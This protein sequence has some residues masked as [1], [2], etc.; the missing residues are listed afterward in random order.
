[1]SLASKGLLQRPANT[2]ESAFKRIHQPQLGGQR[3]PCVSLKPSPAMVNK[4]FV[5]FSK[6]ESAG[7]SGNY[8]RERFAFIRCKSVDPDL[9][10]LPGGIQRFTVGRDGMSTAATSTGSLD[11][12]SSHAS[13]ERHEIE[14]S[15]M[16][17]CSPSVSY[18]PLDSSVSF[19]VSVCG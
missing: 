13:G 8:R 14:D 11:P 4:R 7:L 2:M 9:A 15:E 12:E 3:V 17:D 16:E 5:D 18:P 1:M 10:P 6:S 19:T